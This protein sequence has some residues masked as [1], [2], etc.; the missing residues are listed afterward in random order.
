[1]HRS[2]LITGLVLLTLVAWPNYAPADAD[3]DEQSQSALEGSAKEVAAGS[4]EESDTSS[5][6]GRLM[7]EAGGED[8][9]E[10]DASGIKARQAREIAYF[11]LEGE[12][13]ET[14]E[15][16]S[17]L[18]A[19][20]P[21]SME[22]WLRKL[23]QARNDPKVSAVVLDVADLE[24]GW[25]QVQELRSAIGRIRKAGKP[26]YG[27]LA[28][29]DLK[30][31]M[32]ASACD[33]VMIAPA[34]H[35][36]VPGLFLQVWFYKDLLDK[37]GVQA[38]I[39]HIGAYKGAGEPYTRNAP[40]EELKEQLTQLTDDLYRQ[41]V[42]QIAE[43]RRIA[44]EQVEHLIDT[45]LFS[46]DEAVA[47]GLADEAIGLEEL[48]ANL[49]AEQKATV[50][51][52]YGKKSRGK[53]DLSNPF[54]F[55]KMFS[56]GAGREKGGD[57]P[58]IGLVLLSGYIVD[59]REDSLFESGVIAPEDVR[60]AVDTALEDGN[61]KA[62]VLR[63]DSPGGSALASDIMYSHIRELAAQK[64]V[65]VSMG[66]VAAS[67]GYYIAAAAPTILADPGT[68]TGSIGVLGGKIVV[69]GLLGKIGITTFSVQRGEWAGV[70]DM[71][72]GFTPPQREKVLKLMAD[73][74]GVFKDR[75]LSTRKDKLTRPID[76]IAGGRVYTGQ[77]AKDL[78]LVDQ[79]GGMTEAVYLA[80]EKAGVESYEIRVIPKPR[81][82]F[83]VL[84]EGLFEDV[85]AEARAL[86]AYVGTVLPA[87]KDP[88][89]ASLR[90]IVDRA[91][92]R[93]RL[94]R[95]QPVQMLMPF[96]TN[97]IP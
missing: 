85:D 64:P 71:T 35:L 61:I 15:E 23:A 89:T 68:I 76:D 94:L 22:R 67:G 82:F 54:A 27:Y 2:W 5:L 25:A 13:P 72:S 92:M 21:S 14:L 10:Q 32:V 26:V 74:Y 90:R 63:I 65:V 86:G 31:Y 47:A 96:D 77:R 33:K 9:D 44:Q 50:N 56:Q 91:L 81:N 19:R 17:L 73:I 59:A 69:N 48:L 34:G 43:S 7:A 83:E 6:A 49:E 45:A 88:A 1:M 29:A 97:L 55:F 3:P 30:N 12:I 11:R 62:V 80:A 24:A 60:E 20:K 36:I 46:A 75:V 28:D 40:S 95:N 51:E 39:L 79:I 58:A 52:E 70:F 8:K 87:G 16:M 66:N 78:G 4:E 57:K 42:N 38:E 53:P 93:V 41:I 37:L 84:L 18:S